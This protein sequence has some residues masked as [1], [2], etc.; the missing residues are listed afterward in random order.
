MP[1][2]TS[3]ARNSADQERLA[4]V[5]LERPKR[6]VRAQFNP[7]D[8][9]IEKSPGWN[10]QK[11]TGANAPDL[12]FTGGAARTMSLELL[13]DCFELNDGTLAQDLATL[14]E[15]SLAPD[16]GGK[17]AA[18]RRPPL[19]AVV[20]GPIPGFRCVLDSLS[21]KVTMFN[22]AMQPV[23]AT[24]SVKLKEIRTEQVFEIANPATQNLRAYCCAWDPSD[25]KAREAELA[26]RSPARP[27]TRRR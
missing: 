16:P 24:V 17:V 11:T 4:L 10:E 9:Q 7:T 8:V 21:I 1:F 18:D 12:E 20:N 22:R 6:H 5:D 27:E 14:T 19:L 23:R 3:F 2:R 25:D 15:L 26:K 13:F